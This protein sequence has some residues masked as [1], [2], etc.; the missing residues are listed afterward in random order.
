MYFVSE[1]A[2]VELSQVDECKPLHC[3]PIDTT[4]R[5]AACFPT[6]RL[7]HPGA[8]SAP[9]DP[10]VTARAASAESS[11]GKRVQLPSAWVVCARARRRLFSAPLVTG[12]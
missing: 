7:R 8:G 6:Q 4:Q 1:A 3:T 9:G 10:L 5:G 11:I 12:L 2:Q